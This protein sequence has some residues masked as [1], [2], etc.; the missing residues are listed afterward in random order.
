MK[1]NELKSISESLIDTFNEAGKISIDLYKKG[2]KIEIKEDKSPVRNGDLHVNE[3]ITQKIKK[4]TPNIPVISEETVD[5]K[6]KNK[7]KIFKSKNKIEQHKLVYK[8]LKGK[9][10]NE[11]HAL[12]LNTMEL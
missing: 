9:M 6:V 5:L 8:S 10:G 12:A 4:L 7:S 3:L 1:I 2:L 11:L